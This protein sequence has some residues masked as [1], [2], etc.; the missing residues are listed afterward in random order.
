MFRVG[1]TGNIAAG[2]SAVVALLRDWGA[3][4]LD[5][6]TFAREAVEPGTAG[7]AEIARR[8]GPGVLKTDG[9][10][11]RGAL[12]RRILADP[13]ERLALNFI[14]HPIV[15]RLASEAETRL[16]RRGVR[17]V[18]H[19]IPL[20]FESLD[21]SLY[22]A[23]V[24]VEAPVEVRRG[25]LAARGLPPEEADALIAAQMPSEAKRDRSHF[26]IENSGSRETLEARA[27]VV[28]NEL[29]RR[30]GIA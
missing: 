24:L 19:D 16:V 29:Q 30:A 26:V 2:K 21:P 22:D 23:V 27:R 28:W 13:S 12:R 25:R 15:S 4:V 8:F 10:L 18:V 14:V 11:D 3:E 17:L 1:L 7:L 5:A 9:S 6:D 20:L